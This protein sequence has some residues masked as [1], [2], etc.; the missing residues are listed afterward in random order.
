MHSRATVIA[1]VV[2]LSV[3]LLFLDLLQQINAK[4]GGKVPIHDISRSRFS[5][6]FVLLHNRST[7]MARAS[8]VV[9]R[10]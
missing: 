2:R 5:S 9:V 6:A 1:S 3:K 4:F 10:P 8:V 7:A